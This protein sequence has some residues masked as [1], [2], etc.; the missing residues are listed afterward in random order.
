[1][2][3]GPNGRLGEGSAALAAVRASGTLVHT[4]MRFGTRL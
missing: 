2:S 3:Q 1:M 4:T